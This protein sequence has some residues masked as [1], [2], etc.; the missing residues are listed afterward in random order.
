M[1]HRI[2]VRPIAVF[3]AVA[4][5]GAWLVALPLW[6]S[7]EGLA[8]PGATIYLVAMM[9]TPAIAALVAHRIDRTGRFVDATTLK[10]RTP[11]HRWL[12]YAGIAWLAPI[13]VTLLAVLVSAAFGFYRFDLVEFSG[14][15]KVVTELAGT[16]D[17]GMPIAMLVAIQ[18]ATMFVSPA[19]NV[20]PAMGE[21]LGW[22]GF[23]QTRLLP[24]GQWPAVIVT[25]VVWGLWHAPVI[26]LGYNYPG[27]HPVVALLLMVGFCVLMSVL[28]GWMTIASGTVWTAALAHGFVNGV[29]SMGVL[30]GSADP[31]DSALVGLLGVSG[32]LVM[33]VLI[34]ALVLLRRFPVRDTAEQAD[35]A[36]E[37]AGEPAAAS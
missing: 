23:L 4:F 10:P 16:T 35:A 2:S 32:W 1:T 29:A 13:V 7:G 33:A 34:A 15:E 31:T 5:G 17:I 36:V 9:F 24:L 3:L 12:G 26:L 6:L 30:L 18:L 37:D 25:G 20:I 8:T 14:A 28:L 21:E 27:Q 11:F 19:L 22:R